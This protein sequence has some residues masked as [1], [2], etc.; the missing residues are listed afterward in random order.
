MIAR[1][2]REKEKALHP[3]SISPEISDGAPV[4][5]LTYSTRSNSLKSSMPASQRNRLACSGPPVR[6]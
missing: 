1:K 5:S 3:R 2:I 6:A 4:Y